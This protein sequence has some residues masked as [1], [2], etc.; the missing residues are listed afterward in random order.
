MSGGIYSLTSTPSDR[1][2]RNIFVAGL[3]TLTVLARKLLRGNRQRI[4]FHISLFKGKN[5]K[6]K[7]GLTYPIFFI[8]S[9]TFLFLRERERA[10]ESKL[11]S[12]QFQLDLV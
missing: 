7:A 9:L 4:F 11:A 3:F 10:K 5:G 1:F 6:F 2:V 8:C 12:E